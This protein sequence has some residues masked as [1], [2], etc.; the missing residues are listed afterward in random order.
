MRALR[1]F[2]SVSVGVGLT[3]LLF[4]AVAALNQTSTDVP[5]KSVAKAFV[6]PVIVTSPPENVKTYEP[7]PKDVRTS[8]PKPMS[9]VSRLQPSALPTLGLARTN[10]SLGTL[11]PTLGMVGVGS[12]EVADVP[13]VPSEPDRPARAQRTVEPAYPVSAQRNGIEGFVLLRLTI[14]ANGRVKNIVVVD[15]EPI[16]VFERS[17]RDA[18]RRFEF[19]PARKGGVT[20]QTTI[21]KKIFFTLQ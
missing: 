21:E 5:E 7:L 1:W 17:A 18:A 12:V 9:A 2:V 3:F 20:V 19:T 15:S 14:D 11:L 8:Q 10:L 16:G 13:N 6:Q 4:G